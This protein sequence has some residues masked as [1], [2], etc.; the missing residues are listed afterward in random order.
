MILFDKKIDP[1]VVFDEIDVSES[2]RYD[3]KARIHFFTNFVKDQGE[4]DHN[5]FLDF[6]R[7]LSS[8]N[9]IGVATKNK[10]LATARIF[11]KELN[12]L[13]V[14]PRDIT[15]NVKG[16]N[17]GKKHKRN[18]LDRTQVSIIMEQLRQLTSTAQNTRLKALLTLLIF[19]GLRQIEI[20][21]LNVKDIDLETRSAMVQGKGHDD[22]EPIDLHPETVKAIR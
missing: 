11:L 12:R 14:L 9:D 6:K 2:T 7:Y 13:G 3:Y 20:V 19:Q 1:K 8:R 5:S 21:R 18:G 22:V 10:N 16:F 4:M 17:Q 15:Q